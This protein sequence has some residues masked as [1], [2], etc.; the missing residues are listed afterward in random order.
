VSD[1]SRH[2]SED[3]PARKDAGSGAAGVV[4]GR[5]QPTPPPGWVFPAIAVTLAA[6]IVIGLVIGWNLGNRSSPDAADSTIPPAASTNPAPTSTNPATTSTTADTA[7]AFGTVEV[8][9]DPLPEYGAIDEDKVVG[10]AV[11]EITGHDFSG[12]AVSISNDGRAKIILLV[13]HWCPY[14][15]GEVPIVHDWYAEADLPDNVDV[16][17]IIVWTDPSRDNFPPSAWL[18]S[19]GWTIPVIVDDEQNTAAT[20]IGVSGVPFWVLVNAD[21]TLYTRGSGQLDAEALDQIAL[22]LSEGHQ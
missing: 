21:G 5:S 2:G 22:E 4:V 9:G 11:P 14:C 13:A 18:E 10:S 17:S 6:G 19:E 1:K 16:Y 15:Q 20:A 7:P 12:N 8:S 3:T